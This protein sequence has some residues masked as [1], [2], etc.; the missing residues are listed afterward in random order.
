[1]KGDKNYM[2]ACKGP[3]PYSYTWT[4]DICQVK[5]ESKFT[6]LITGADAGM[7]R[8]QTLVEA[9]PDNVI[10][11]CAY[12]R[13]TQGWA[14]ASQDWAARQAPGY[15]SDTTWQTFKPK[16]EQDLSTEPRTFRNFHLPVEK[17]YLWGQI[18]FQYDWQDTAENKAGF[19]YYN[20]AWRHENETWVFTKNACDCKSP[21]GDTAGACKECN[22]KI[23]G[24][25]LKRIKPNC[26]VKFGLSDSD[27]PYTLEG[28]SGGPTLYPPETTGVSPLVEGGGPG[29][30]RLC[31]MYSWVKG[32]MIRDRASV[33]STCRQ[34]QTVQGGSSEAA[35]R[36]EG[37]SD[38]DDPTSDA[39]S[40]RA[41]GMAGWVLAVFAA[42]AALLAAQ[43]RGEWL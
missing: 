2:N 38:P 25:G 13:T 4:F 30:A 27:C 19:L 3:F 8:S 12:R 28:V 42:F 23:P 37:S 15:P 18:C 39:S 11:L 1:M 29:G 26:L 14:G 36:R 21:R 6:A 40:R 43:A 5:G 10:Q 22:E 31:Y 24:T 7:T 20:G 33:A 35:S 17:P 34:S 16:N 32:T 41:G 9:T